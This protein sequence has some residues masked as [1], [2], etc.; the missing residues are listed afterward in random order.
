MVG[1][2]VGKWELNQAM[3]QVGGCGTSRKRQDSIADDLL[4]TPM[5]VLVAP[6]WMCAAALP[7]LN[8]DTTLR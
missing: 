3:R 4:R 5:A 1:E 7:L 8:R 6:I 2:Q